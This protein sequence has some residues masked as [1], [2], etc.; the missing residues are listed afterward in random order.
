MQQKH[1]ESVYRAQEQNPAEQA[2][3]APLVQ[4]CREYE[5]RR[6][7][8]AANKKGYHAQRIL[9]PDWEALL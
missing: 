1:T 8:H 9:N 4:E 7:P 6:E 5:H 3:A 2:Q